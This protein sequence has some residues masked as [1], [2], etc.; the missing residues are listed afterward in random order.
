MEDLNK[1]RLFRMT[2]IEN[3]PHILQYGITH[4]SSANTN[5][6]FRPIGDRSLIGTR[7]EKQLPNGDA[8]GDYI[9]FYFGT[10]MPM[11]FVLQ[12]GF[13]SLPVTSPNSIIYCISSVQKVLDHDLSF[14]FTDGH[15]VNSLSNFYSKSDLENIG[16]ILD[17]KAIKAEW[18]NTDLDFKR[19]K[20]AEFLLKN[21]MPLEAI[22][23][24]AVYSD[25]ARK[26]LENMGIPSDKIITKPNFYF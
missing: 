18:W 9:P 7:N 20:E 16:T 1:I 3:I 12:R 23:G 22:L 11:L 10:R 15:A 8:L 6:N 24:Y 19:R 13:N 26:E 4:L 17:F 5:P 2:H 14:L 21:D 25:T